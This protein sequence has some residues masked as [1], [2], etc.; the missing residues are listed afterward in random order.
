[1][2]CLLLF[3]QFCTGMENKLWDELLMGNEQAFMTLYND[4]YKVLFSFGCRV[5]ANRQTVKDAIHDM[6]CEI[7]DNHNR[8]PRVE[9]VPAYLM[10]YLKRKLLK[11][12]T[13]EEKHAFL[14]KEERSEFQPEISYE[15]ML[16]NLETDQEM[17]ERLRFFLQKLSPAHLQIIQLK[18]YEGLSYEQIAIMLSLQPRT[19]YNKVYESLKLLRKH[20]NTIALLIVCLF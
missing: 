18:F 3:L 15:D 14:L 19:V 17:K 9:N 12:I 10:T 6:F 20:L 5:Y 4:T 8:L 11:E 2:A 16:I 1:M 7:W 13:I